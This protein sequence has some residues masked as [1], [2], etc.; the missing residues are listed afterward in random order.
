MIPYYVL[1]VTR[2]PGTYVLSMDTDKVV[3][4]D[5]REAAEKFLWDRDAL[6]ALMIHVKEMTAPLPKPF[7]DLYEIHDGEDDV[8]PYRFVD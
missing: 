6:I 3:T 8:N 1:E 2:R 7:D 5:T 4:F